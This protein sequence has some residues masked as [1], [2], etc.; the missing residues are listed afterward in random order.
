MSVQVYASGR[1]I[2]I[3][4]GR[5]KHI[6]TLL[7]ADLGYGE[8][9]INCVHCSELVG[10]IAISWGS[11]VV[12]FQPE[13][14]D[15]NHVQNNNE[16]LY[17]MYVYKL[18]LSYM[19]V[20]TFMHSCSR[21]NVQNRDFH[22]NCIFPTSLYHCTIKKPLYLA[23]LHN[24]YTFF[25]AHSSLATGVSPTQCPSITP[26]SPSRGTKKASGCSSEAR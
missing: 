3:L 22:Y 25:L 13:P 11:D 4:D 6:Q 16:V 7:G 23:S 9:P 24:P 12:I 1:D 2:V 5:L 20:Y 19:H 8:T 21:V 15:E 17:I 26:S 14:L 10:K 18:Y